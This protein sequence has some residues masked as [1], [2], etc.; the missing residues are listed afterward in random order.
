MTQLYEYELVKAASILANN[1]FCLKP[2]ET[3]QL[4]PR[5]I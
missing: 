2:G 5:A 1:M 4:I 3:L